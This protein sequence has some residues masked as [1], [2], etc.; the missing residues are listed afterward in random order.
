[1][2][3]VNLRLHGQACRICRSPNREAIEAA[4]LDWRPQTEIAREFRLGGRQVVYRHARALGLFR[5]RDENVRAVL[6]TFIERSSRVRPTAAAFIAAVSVLS[7]LDSEGRHVERIEQ[8]NGLGALFAQMTRAECLAYAETG[9]L[10][11]WFIQAAPDTA[12][13]ASEDSNA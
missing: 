9:K 5:K 4:F 7:K 12:V 11:T 10:P 3:K 8:S 13:R 1:M 2:K 6:G